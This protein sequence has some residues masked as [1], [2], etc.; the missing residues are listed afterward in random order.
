M[1]LAKYLPFFL[2]VGAA[3]ALKSDKECDLKHAIDKCIKSDF[4][5]DSHDKKMKVLPKDANEMNTMCENVKHAETCTRDF[6]DKCAEHDKEKSTLDHSLDGMVRVVKRVCQTEDKKNEFLVHSEKCGNAIL[7]DGKKCLNEY[8]KHLMVAHKLDD[9]DKIKKIMCCKIKDVPACLEMRMKEKGDEI[10]N[11]KDMEYF[12]KV[13]H[14][15]KEELLQSMCTDFDDETKCTG[16]DMH[17]EIKDIKEPV[18]DK[19]LTELLKGTMDKI[20]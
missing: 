6:I 15:L 8:K 19:C 1:F 16:I 7:P 9:K 10:C 13:R 14:A 11:E 4:L 3:I 20:L 17:A 12:K 2:L 5:I 18:E